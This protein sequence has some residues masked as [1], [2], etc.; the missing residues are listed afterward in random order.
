[1]KLDPHKAVMPGS[2][3]WVKMV[4]FRLK[5]GFGVEDVAVQLRCDVERVRG[6]VAALRASGDLKAIVT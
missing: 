4:E 1:M 3:I 2:P 6:H 5:E